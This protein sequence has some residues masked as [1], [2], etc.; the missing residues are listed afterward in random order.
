MVGS[1]RFL[2]GFSFVWSVVVHW[3]KKGME[4]WVVARSKVGVVSCGGLTLMESGWLVGAEAW[5]NSGF[6][7]IFLVFFFAFVS[8]LPHSSL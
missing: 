4:V 1:G 3:T 2:V 6:A 5:M 7:M 8:I